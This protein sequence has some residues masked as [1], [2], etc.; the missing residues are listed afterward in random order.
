MAVHRYLNILS[1]V[2]TPSNRGSNAPIT[3]LGVQSLSTTEGASMIKAAGD[4]DAGPTSMDIDFMEPVLAVKFEGIEPALLAPLTG[5]RG[6]VIAIIGQSGQ[7]GTNGA[8]QV[9]LNPMLTIT[10]NTNSAFRKYSDSDVEFHGIFG[11]GT[12]PLS[13]T[14]IT[15]SQAAG[16][17]VD[18][19]LAQMS[20]PPVMDQAAGI[21]TVE[22][23]HFGPVDPAG[24]SMFVPLGLKATP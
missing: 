19:D 21:G 1:L 3:L 9:T 7:V 23:C 16:P 15:L 8:L 5:I 22:D 20:G 10:K 12:N 13:V 11:N 17:P 24:P 4:G 14:Q 6:S 18:G 2:I